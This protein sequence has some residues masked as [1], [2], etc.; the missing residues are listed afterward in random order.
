MASRA[1]T[2]ET[3]RQKRPYRSHEERRREIMDA[4]LTILVE[5]GA[6]AWTTAA[7]AARAGVSEA[8]LFKHFSNKEEIL[9]ATFQAQASA[10]RERISAYAADGSPWEQAEGLVIHV[11]RSVEEA[12]GGPLLILLGHAARIQPAMG[13]DVEKT[14]ALFRDRLQTLLSQDSSGQP[15]SQAQVPVLAELLVAVTQSSALR[16]MAFG[17]KRSLCRIA[18]PMLRL[19]RR[20]AGALTQ[21]VGG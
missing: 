16:W 13:K 10:L 21:E 2:A 12:G 17:R 6:H 1:S 15:V 18:A 19:L 20:C 5:E 3:T 9:I 14:A 8:T 7:L 11:L 4:T